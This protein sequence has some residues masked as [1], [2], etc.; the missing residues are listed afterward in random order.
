MQ[1]IGVARQLM[2]QHVEHYRAFE[3]SARHF[4]AFGCFFNPTLWID[5][6]G[7]DSFKKQQRLVRAAIKFLE[8]V[9]AETDSP[10]LPERF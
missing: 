8:A 1:A 2:Q 6:Q 5:V 7:S 9:A 3:D 10:G 4:E